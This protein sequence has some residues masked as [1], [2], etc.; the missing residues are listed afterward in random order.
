MCAG[1]LTPVTLRQVDVDDQRLYLGET[2]RTHTCRSAE[3]IRSWRMQ[4]G[5]A[6]GKIVEGQVTL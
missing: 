1:D 5:D 2:E 4:R 6:G 3:D